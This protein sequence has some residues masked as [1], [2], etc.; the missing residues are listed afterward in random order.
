LVS[1]VQAWKVKGV[2][3]PKPYERVLKVLMAPEEGSTKDFTMLISLISPDS[4]TN[5]HAHDESGEIMYVLSGRGECIIEGKT[6]GLEPDTAVYIPLGVRHQ[7]KNAS[8]EGMKIICVF[9]PPLVSRYVED[10]E[11]IN[12]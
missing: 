8:D 1:V 10:I 7:I 2:K 3:V 9:I 6:Y 4:E 5:Y 11:K 12:R